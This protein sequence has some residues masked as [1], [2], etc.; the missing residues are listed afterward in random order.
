MTAERGVRVLLIEQ[1]MTLGSNSRMPPMQPARAVRQVGD[2]DYGAA[3]MKRRRSVLI[4]DAALA[5]IVATMLFAAWKV[6]AFA[7]AIGP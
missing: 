4:R 3:V 6:I 2:A 5:I 1:L 7:F